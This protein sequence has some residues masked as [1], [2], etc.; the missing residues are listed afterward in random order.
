[1]H[2]VAPR[3]VAEWT[4][5]YFAVAGHTAPP[6]RNADPYNNKNPRNLLF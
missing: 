6:N 4:L 5:I 2:T 1:M 3:S